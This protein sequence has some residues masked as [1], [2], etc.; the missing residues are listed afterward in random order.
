MTVALTELVKPPELALMV[1]VPCACAVTVP[2]AT[3]ATCVLL[4]VQ[5]ELLVISTPV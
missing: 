5:V 3:V 1:T 2:P 4:E